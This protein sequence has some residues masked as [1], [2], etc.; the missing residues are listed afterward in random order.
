VVD[1]P[2]PDSPT[3]LARID[4]E[5]DPVDGAYVTD[6]PPDQSTSLDGEELLQAGHLEDR[7]PGVRRRDAGFLLE[8]CH[9]CP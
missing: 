4:L 2:Q 5:V 1:L 7:F 6:D 8:G 3:S 9:T